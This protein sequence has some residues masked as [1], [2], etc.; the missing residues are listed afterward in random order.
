LGTT[1]AF[2]GR[3]ATTLP[4]QDLFPHHFPIFISSDK[5]KRSTRTHASNSGLRS[6]FHYTLLTKRA[7][8]SL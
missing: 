7:T 6:Y 4:I 3:I 8:N 5:Q 1:G 2:S